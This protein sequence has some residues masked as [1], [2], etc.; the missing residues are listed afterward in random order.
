MPRHGRPRSQ[1]R[2]PRGRLI[3]W[4]AEMFACA[5]VAAISSGT[6]VWPPVGGPAIMVAL[7]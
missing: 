1:G 6:L 4:T 5:T 7:R 3:Y 2:A